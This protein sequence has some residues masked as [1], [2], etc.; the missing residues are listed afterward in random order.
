MPP[1]ERFGGA[2][3]LLGVDERLV[4]RAWVADDFELNASGASGPPAAIHER[5][6]VLR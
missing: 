3:D 1:F 5:L 6:V 2:V 4:R